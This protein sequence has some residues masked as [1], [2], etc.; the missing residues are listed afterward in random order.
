[1]YKQFEQKQLLLS[2]NRAA[3]TYASAIALPKE[4]GLRLF[5]RLDLMRLQPEVI[6]DLGCATGYLTKE[7]AKRY[8]KAK[9]LGI[10]LAFN[11]VRHAK[12][13]AG[14]L[15]RERF[16]NADAYYLPLASQSVDLIFSNLTFAWCIDIDALL[17]ELNRVLKPEGLLLF[18]TLGPDTLQEL[19][20]SWQTIDAY[21][22]LHP[23]LDMHDIGD[24][25]VKTR[26]QDPVMDMEKLT[27]N[28]S[29]LST[30]MKDIKALGMHNIAVG[31]NHGLTTP[32]QLEKLKQAYEKHRDT[33]GIL[34]TTFEVIYGHAWSHDSI[35][36]AANNV[37]EVMIPVSKI[38][39]KH[40]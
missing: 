39:R 5:E 16:I 40:I 8:R 18:T 13:Q 37:G 12:A 19:K 31:K 33:A 28:Y 14:W 15:S 6:V 2:F 3:N 22:H 27:V 11:M 24:S 9:V 25:L 4:I 36:F 7:L 29:Q 20:Q 34:P 17:I 23:F 26:F 30:L 38:K 10:D 35:T 1:M 32:R 21:Q